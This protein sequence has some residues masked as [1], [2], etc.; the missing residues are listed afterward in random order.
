MHLL[1]SFSHLY[2]TAKCCFSPS[3]PTFLKVPRHFDPDVDHHKNP[4]IFLLKRIRGRPAEGG[5]DN[6]EPCQHSQERHQVHPP[7]CHRLQ[8]AGQQV[9]WAIVHY[10]ASFIVKEK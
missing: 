3:I 6:R 9:K 8:A 1:C 2:V 10:K 5:E 4:F 7:L